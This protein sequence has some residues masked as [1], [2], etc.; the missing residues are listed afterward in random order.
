MWVGTGRPPKDIMGI[1][2]NLPTCACG[3]MSPPVTFGPSIISHV[4]APSY[5][6]SLMERRG[7]SKQRLL[8]AE[9]S[10]RYYVAC[11]LMALDFLHS[12]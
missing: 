7:P 5:L 1:Q 3:A 9:S 10:A 11:L 6:Q 8:M 4:A 12:K 2:R